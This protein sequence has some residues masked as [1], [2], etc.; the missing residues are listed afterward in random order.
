MRKKKK[1]FSFKD[2]IRKS[3]WAFLIATI[4]VLLTP[5]PDKDTSEKLDDRIDWN[6]F[7]SKPKGNEAFLKYLENQ[8]YSIT[9]NQLPLLIEI[10]KKQVDRNPND[11]VKELAEIAHRMTGKSVKVILQTWGGKYIAEYQ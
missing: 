6:S 5:T 2:L 8:G 11:V 1:E 9:K 3:A 10:E 4:L 7:Y